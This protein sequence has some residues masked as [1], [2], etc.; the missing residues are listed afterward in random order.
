M[1]LLLKGHG[2]GVEV[3]VKLGDRVAVG[4]IN[5]DVGAGG[6]GVEVEVV[7]EAKVAIL[8]SAV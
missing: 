7:R 3:G 4:G 8:D 5:V 2:V 1:K 6:I